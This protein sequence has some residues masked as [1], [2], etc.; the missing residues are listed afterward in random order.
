VKTAMKQYLLIMTSVTFLT[1]TAAFAV[2]L[3]EADYNYLESQ[4]I[5][6]SSILIR[7]LS[8]REQAR[9]HALINDEQTKNNPLAQAEN[10]NEALRGFSRNQLWEQQNPGQLWDTPRR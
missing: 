4:E 2:G 5:E 1:A 8:P 6:R 3:T 10:V 7:G 9:L